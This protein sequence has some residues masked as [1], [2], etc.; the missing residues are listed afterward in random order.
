[1]KASILFYT[2]LAVFVTTAVVALLG[3]LGAVSIEGTVL[4]LLV[5]ALLVETAAAVIAL[6]R[7]TDF[8]S[9]DRARRSDSL[10]ST[11]GQTIETFDRL[12]DEIEAAIQ[13]QP[14]AEESRPHRFLIRRTGKHDVA[15]YERMQVISGDQLDRLSPVT[16]K[17]VATY[18]KSMEALER[19]WTRIKEE[20]AT[21]QLDPAVRDQQIELIRTMKKDLVGVVDFLGEQ[22]I[23]LDDHYLTVRDLV[24]QV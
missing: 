18:A 4:N 7:R 10:V 1:M 14:V 8:L 24:A 22:N 21:S 17:R 19:E 3:V 11:L 16:R 15:V 13:N 20:R 6:F 23:Y 2:L 12:S 5:T 9:E